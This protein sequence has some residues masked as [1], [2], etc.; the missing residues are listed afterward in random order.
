MRALH[1]TQ[2][3]AYSAGLEPRGVDPLAVKV[4]AEVGVDISNHR[5]KHLGEFQGWE[6]DYVIT[7]C[8]HAREVCPV[9]PAKVKLMHRG[10][11]DPAQLA[12]T[13]SDEEEAVQHYRRVR[14]EIR[15]FVSDLPR[16]IEQPK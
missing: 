12:A 10:F 7:L 3:E 5:S 1:P 9:F 8:D 6:F 16:L 2:F 13:C 4:M 11:D 15:A 14:D